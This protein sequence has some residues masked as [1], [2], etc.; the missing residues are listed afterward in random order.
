MNNADT[1]EIETRLDP[2]FRNGSVTAVGIVSGFSL[3]FITRWATNPVPWDV[4]DVFALVPLIAG[5]AL[6]V[7]AIHILLSPDSLRLSVYGRARRSF[8][9]GLVLTTI[10]CSIAIAVDAIEAA[11][12]R[13]IS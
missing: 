3:S 7:L 13:L 6:Q 10:G 8:V 2:T 12:G 5:T 9:V 1:D 4:L 11:P